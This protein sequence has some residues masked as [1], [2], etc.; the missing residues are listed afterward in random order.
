LGEGGRKGKG[1][2]EV[3]GAAGACAAGLR[4]ADAEPPE[5]GR[6]GRGRSSCRGGSRPCRPGRR[7]AGAGGADGLKGPEA[8]ELQQRSHFVNACAPRTPL[9]LCVCGGEAFPPS[10][11][12]R[13][14][15]DATGRPTGRQMVSRVRCAHTACTCGQAKGAPRGQR[16]GPG[17]T[18]HPLGPRAAVATLAG[19]GRADPGW[20][21]LSRVGQGP[22]CRAG[23]ESAGRAGPGIRV[24]T[25]SRARHRTV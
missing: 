22:T 23:P 14:P 5:L 25:S 24:A 15:G 3:G 12:A 19:P 2:G 8:G 11:P 18:T 9:R 10:D 7:A 16:A 4:V 13:L 1:V 20:A 21:G 17:P 6:R